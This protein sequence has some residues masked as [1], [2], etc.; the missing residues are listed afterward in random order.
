[1]KKIIYALIIF[2]IVLI[3]SE[4][5]I[6][7]NSLT[8]VNSAKH[9]SYIDFNMDRITGEPELVS[10]KSSLTL[11]DFNDVSITPEH[12]ID[13]KSQRSSNGVY[14]L[15]IPISPF[16]LRSG[17]L[18]VSIEFKVVKQSA[19]SFASS[20]S[21]GIG[22]TTG[23][24]RVDSGWGVKVP[25]YYGIFYY[26]FDTRYPKL[27]INGITVST[28]ILSTGSV[29]SYSKD[30]VI[31]VNPIRVDS[32]L[33]IIGGG[34]ITTSPYCEIEIRKLRIVSYVMSEVI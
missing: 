32:L 6:S 13:V 34:G 18:R 29:Y 33:F 9:I 11:Q 15:R 8:F 21:I 12:Y 2:M 5:V 26:S 3:N 22:N 27:V 28:S 17:F 7:K 1:M 25:N 24:Y 30:Q 4:H 23:I 16:L 20:I 19:S 31:K 10:A 14:L